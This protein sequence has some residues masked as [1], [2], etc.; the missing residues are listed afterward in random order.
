[1]IQANLEAPS[2]LLD[3]PSLERFE[4]ELRTVPYDVV[5]ISAI[6]PNVGR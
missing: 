4:E 2:T 1:M 6:L 5:G 3:F